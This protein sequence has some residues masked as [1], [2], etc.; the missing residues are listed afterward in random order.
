[1]L[2]QNFKV[3]IKMSPQIPKK[4]INYIHILIA[5]GLS[6]QD[7]NSMSCEEFW[8]KALDIDSETDLN[9]KLKEYKIHEL[10]SKIPKKDYKWIKMLRY[11][12]GY[13]QGE[14]VRWSNE[15]FWFTVLGY[16][17]EAVEDY[18]NGME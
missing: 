6:P 3:K 1:M 18:I 10:R 12:H 9:S 8:M 15:E 5:M 14:I 7:I 11:G 4:N 2:K 16:F 17:P 13:D